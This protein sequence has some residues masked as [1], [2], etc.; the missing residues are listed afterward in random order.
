[1]YCHKTFRK[2]SSFL[3]HVSSIKCNKEPVEADQSK[4]LYT[5]SRR[6]L[7]RDKVDSALLVEEEKRSKKR[8]SNAVDLGTDHSRSKMARV[9]GGDQVAP[10]QDA[11]PLSEPDTPV[12]LVP[13]QAAQPLS[14]EFETPSAAWDLWLSCAAVH[15]KISISQPPPDFTNSVGFFNTILSDER[16][17]DHPM[18]P[19]PY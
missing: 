15:D 19:K 6:D 10:H 8:P 18:N 12:T 1:M 14:Q 5:L 7:M 4:N 9:G 11:L 13:Q 3:R 16:H 2:A 17:V